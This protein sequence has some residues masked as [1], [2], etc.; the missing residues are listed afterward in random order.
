MGGDLVAD[1]RGLLAR[2]VPLAFDVFLFGFSSTVHSPTCYDDQ[3]Y[4]VSKAALRVDQMCR[5]AN[6]LRKNCG[7]ER[8]HRIPEP[9]FNL[10]IPHGRVPWFVLFYAVAPPSMNQKK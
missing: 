5:P 8:A 2:D 7:M 6:T 3:L 10:A 1:L 9:S 4:R